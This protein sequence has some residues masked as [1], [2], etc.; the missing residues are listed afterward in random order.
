MT[1]DFNNYFTNAANSSA[2]DSERKALPIV[3]FPPQ[4]AGEEVTAYVILQKPFSDLQAFVQHNFWNL[5]S[6]G[7]IKN[8]NFP[9]LEKFGVPCIGCAIDALYGVGKEEN[10]CKTSKSFMLPVLQ[11]SA[12]EKGK[13]VGELTPKMW[14]VKA[15]L[16]KDLRS[17]E[18]E[19]GDLTGHLIAIKKSGTK[20][21]TR[22][23]LMSRGASGVD[24]TQYAVIEPHEV[25]PFFNK[26]DNPQA[27]SEYAAKLLETQFK[28]IVP[29]FYNV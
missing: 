21:A 14:M 10:P 29:T 26:F 12:L 18:N 27:M 24:L 9:C 6:N 17:N 16:L 1:I 2:N 28:S 19:F 23:S 25:I 22:Y 4:N 13:V 8:V 7:E 5:T 11:A 15:S 20:Q 3:T